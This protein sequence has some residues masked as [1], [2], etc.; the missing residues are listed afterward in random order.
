MSNKKKV[1]ILNINFDSI[2]SND[3]VN[4]LSE[5]INSSLKTF[6]VT[7]NPEI[8]MHGNND[9]DYLKLVNDADYVIADG[10]GIILGSKITGNEIPERIAGFDLMTSLL[11]KGNEKGWNVY[12][13]GAK[14]EVINKAVGKIKDTFPQLNVVGWH[15][16]YGDVNSKGFQMDIASK[17]PDLIFVG[18]GFPVQENW[19]ANSLPLFKKGLFMGVGGSFD[20]W[21]GEV[22]RAPEI[23]QKLNVEWLYRLIQQPTRW[24]RMTVLPIF[25][26][27]VMTE[28]LR[29]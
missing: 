4:K 10:Y 14:E 6:V 2:H 18:L 17:E 15:N 11:A 1:N 23:W 24:R 13:L 29:K 25:V 12:F 16:G 22:K 9:L 21:A 20:V 7:A 19:I 5:R 27:K 26:L 3:L 28:R 8:V